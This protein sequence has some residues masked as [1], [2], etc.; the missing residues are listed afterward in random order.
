MKLMNRLK[1]TKKNWQ[2]WRDK[3]V[4]ARCSECGIS[5]E[6]IKATDD[7]LCDYCY[8]VYMEEAYDSKKP[9]SKPAMGG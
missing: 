5:V 4:K 9:K 1:R 7:L 3:R 6:V 8:E 2:D